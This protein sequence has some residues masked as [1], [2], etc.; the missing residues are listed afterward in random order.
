MKAVLDSFYRNPEEKG[1]LPR[2]EGIQKGCKEAE[3]EMQ[4]S[5]EGRGKLQEGFAR[6]LKK[7]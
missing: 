2:R 5:G 3:A 4:F 1:S 7:L 6:S